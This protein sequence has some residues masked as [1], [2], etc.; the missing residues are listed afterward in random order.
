MVGMVAVARTTLDP[1]G[2]V[3]VHGERWQA[4]LDEGKVKIGEEVVI[5]E[6]DGLRLRVTKKNRGGE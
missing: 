1:T 4:T 5:T 6:V 2:T 3:F